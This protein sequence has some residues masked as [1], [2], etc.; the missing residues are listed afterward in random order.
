MGGGGG[1]DHEIFLFIQIEVI[2]AVL[3][4]IRRIFEHDDALLTF[5][6]MYFGH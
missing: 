2:S 6:L 4:R 3:S 1:D 5:F